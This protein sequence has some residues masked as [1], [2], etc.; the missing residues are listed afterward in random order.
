MRIRQAAAAVGAVIGL[1]TIG[2]GLAQAQVLDASPAR[3]SLPTTQVSYPF[4]WD[5]YRC[6]DP[7][8]RSPSWCGP[9][10]YSYRDCPQCGYGY[11]PRN[12]WR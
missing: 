8:Y 12:Y 7:F 5:D 3:S 1:A 10:G 4:G 2:G 11:Y 6:N 9:I